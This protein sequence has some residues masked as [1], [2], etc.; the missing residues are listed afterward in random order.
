MYNPVTQVQVPKDM[1]LGSYYLKIKSL[2]A[3]STVFLIKK[4]AGSTASDNHQLLHIGF[5][6]ICGTIITL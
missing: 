2:G 3:S 6:P 4:I 5:M 1:N